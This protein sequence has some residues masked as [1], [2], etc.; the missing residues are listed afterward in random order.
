MFDR[1]VWRTGDVARKGVIML[2]ASAMGG[3]VLCLV[4]V[5]P[6]KACDVGVRLVVEW[7]GDVT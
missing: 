6:G 7:T 1:F 5:I 3:A 2:A 4:K